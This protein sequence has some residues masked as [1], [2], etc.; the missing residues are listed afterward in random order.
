MPSDN[1]FVHLH[2]HTEYSLL[3]GLS[4]IPRLVNHAKDLG[5]TALAIT[6]HG[7]MFGVIDF[8][9]ACKKAEIKPIIGVEAYVARRRMTDR[10]SKLDTRPFHLLLL[11][12]N[13]TGYK[14]L[15]KIASAAQLEGYYYRPRIDREFLEQHSEGL[16]ATSG[17]LAA[18]I[19]SLVMEGR[20]QDARDMID[21]YVQV[22]GKDH[23]YLELQSHDID[24][25]RTVNDWLVANGK[26]DVVQLLATND[27]HYVFE[28]DYDPHDTLLCIQTGALK[29][30]TNRLKMTDNSYFLASNAQ[31]W[32]AFGHINDGEALYNSL[33]IAEM[34]EIDLDS[35]GYHLPIFP[36]PDGYDSGTYLRYLC[37]KGLR[38]RYGDRFAEPE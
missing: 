24:E 16:I 10:D 22:F 26:R 8:Y 30:E 38:W 17:C 31:M 33:K 25:L 19:P 6:D 3:D 23:F 35:K 32:D 7:T 34:C 36:V 29:H 14:N 12:Q 20:D 27:V 18:Q 9:R 13:Q 15:L 1:E 5:Q 11:A 21:W 37:E 4:Q 2:V 28:D